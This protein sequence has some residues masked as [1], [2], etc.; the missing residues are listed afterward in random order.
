MN[1][2]RL[3]GHRG[4]QAHGHSQL[5]RARRRAVGRRH[6]RP[7]RALRRIGRNHL[8]TAEGQ[9]ERQSEIR[10]QQN[11]QHPGDR[12][13]RVAAL[14]Q[15]VRRRNVDHQPD[16][17]RQGVE[18]FPVADDQ[19]RQRG[20]KITHRASSS[21]AWRAA[22]YRHGATRRAARSRRATAGPQRTPRPHSPSA[23]AS[24][25]APPDP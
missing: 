8:A 5:L 11:P 12:R 16:R 9:I 20:E 6:R 17:D 15:G 7:P 24:F 1:A 22:L 3:I 10:H 4:R 21:W 14:V 19:R 23:A 2:Q 25:R 13:R 18:H